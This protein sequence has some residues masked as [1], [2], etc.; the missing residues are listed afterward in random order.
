M[1]GHLFKILKKRPAPVTTIPLGELATLW[2]DPDE[3][4]PVAKEGKVADAANDSVIND[5]GQA[6]SPPVD[7]AVLIGAG[8]TPPVNSDD[9]WFDKKA[10]LATLQSHISAGCISAFVYHGTAYYTLE[11]VSRALSEQRRNFDHKPLTPNEVIAFFKSDSGPER[12]LSSGKYLLRFDKGLP[13]K[14]YLYTHPVTGEK[15]SGP[16]LPVDE[17][18]RRLKSLTPIKGH[19]P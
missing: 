18:G 10:L 9:P 11:T 2:L 12:G 3:P 5:P 13:V 15:A 6:E 1:I 17:T 4:K 16:T 14:V 8:K 7:L 19:T